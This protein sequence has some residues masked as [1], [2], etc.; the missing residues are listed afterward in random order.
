MRFAVQNPLW[1]LVLIV[2]GEVGV[3][4]LWGVLR[5]LDRELWGK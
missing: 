3:L 2:V 4:I 5:K 1:L